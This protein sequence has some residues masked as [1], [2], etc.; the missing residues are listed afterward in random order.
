MTAFLTWYLILQ[1]LGLIALPIA[2][3]V[4]RHLPDRG[5][6]LSKALGL[7]LTGY[8]L[9]LL[10]SFGFLRNTRIAIVFVM[11]LVAAFAAYL[12]FAQR[13]ELWAFL[14]RNRRLI[15]VVEVLFF[16]SFA[17]W[18]AYRAYTPQ[19]DHT[20]KPMELAFLNAIRRSATFPPHDPWLAGYPISY[21]YFGYVMAATLIKL[22]GVPSAVGFN[23]MIGLLFALTV[24]GAFGVTYNL[25]R[26]SNLQSR[27]SNLQSPK[28]RDWRLEIGDWA[29]ALLGSL[30]VAVIGN[31]EGF[32][33]VLH[34][35][36]IGPARFWVWLDI[37][38]INT[39]P[40]PG[41]WIPER[42]WWWWRA[43]RVITQRDLLG[44]HV[45]IIDEFP[46]F[47][48]ML[49]DMHPHLLALPFVM[50]ALGLALNILTGVG[51]DEEW[52]PVPRFT[53]QALLLPLIVGNFVFLH[54]WDFP[55]Y[56]ALVVAAYGMRRYLELGTL[57]RTWLRDVASFAVW[58]GGVGLLFFLPYLVGPRPYTGGIG[59]VG[60]IKT[61]LRQ[62][63]VMFGPF[64]FVAGSLVAA[65][66]GDWW[67]SVRQEG[68]GSEVWAVAVTLVPVAALSLL[69]GWWTAAFLAL[70]LGLT[71]VVLAHDLR[72]EVLRAEMVEKVT[73]EPVMA[74]GVGNPVARS[75]QD[76]TSD[77]SPSGAVGDRPEQMETGESGGRRSAVGGQ[78]S[79]VAPAVGDRHSA[80]SPAVLFALLLIAAALTLTLAT[81]FV[82]VRDRFGTRMNTVFKLYYQ[83]WV[84]LAIAAAFGVSHL[85]RRWRGI[86]RSVWATA[87]I[88]LVLMGMVYPVA[89]GYT[90]ANRFRGPATLD[91][92][93][94]LRA[95]RPAEYAAIQWLNERVPDAPVILEA[96]GESYRP[97]TSRF[98]SATGLPTLLGWE[99]HEIQ[100][101]E[102]V[103]EMDQ[104]R[105]DVAAMYQATSV[106]QVKQLLDKYD[107]EYVVVGP[108]ERTKYGLTPMQIEK[109]DRFME[110]V[111]DQDDVR[112]YRR[113][114]GVN[115]RR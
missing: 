35:R 70:F 5:Y 13:A 112:I 80:V 96:T 93:A 7:L 114:G 34:S 66:L 75:D 81:E 111:F 2:F 8:G 50:L 108:T 88:A 68:V 98:S 52:L 51:Q 97:D 46:F 85:L 38:D 92:L 84:M 74:A 28:I 109:F 17:L 67:R 44:N 90:R 78:R 45:E 64:L 25:V 14:N 102:P 63:V 77:R 49:G 82:F 20:E 42:N 86:P 58:L 19:L 16:V 61:K 32:L 87:L 105:A 73:G 94:Y 59:L 55:T 65:R 56:F 23:V 3:R 21:Y 11:L 9:W 39:P 47:S 4:L 100:W 33:D 22:S 57:R 26:I 31:L 113:R 54:S 40:T 71:V 110:R 43:S 95:Y 62:F 18:T 10:V 104:R 69:L 76:Q 29:F 30:F 6:T 12:G 72:R 48:F 41:G 1:L 89:A 91:G 103:P 36:G 27:I 115:A 24:V 37:L 107:I 83:A 99:F 15:L 79:A 106:A 101:R 60:I 53:P